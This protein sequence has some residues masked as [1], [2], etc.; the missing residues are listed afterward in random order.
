LSSVSTS[1]DFVAVTG[2]LPLGGSSTFLLNLTLARGAAGRGTDIIVLSADPPFAAD[3]RAAGATVTPLPDPGAIY[4]DRL[5]Q[6]YAILAARE[7]RAVLST[8]SAESFELLR[9]VPPGVARVGMIQ[10]H[11]PGPYRLAKLYAD[12]LDAVVGVSD[13]ICRSLRS[14]PVFAQTRIELI[15]YGIDFRS[16]SSRLTLPIGAPLRICYLG[17]LVEEQK[18][19]SRLA[20]LSERLEARQIHHRLTIAGEGPEE[21]RLRVALAGRRD[22][23][24]RGPIPNREVGQFF[25][26]QDVFVLLSDYEGLPLTLLEAMGAG[27]VPVVSDLVSGMREVVNESRG[28]LV[29]VDDIDAAVDAIRHLAGNREQL[30]SLSVAATAYVRDQFS[31]KKM[32]ARFQQLVSELGSERPIWPAEVRVPTPRGLRASW[33]FRGAPRVLRRLF[34]RAG[35][36]RPA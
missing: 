35:L 9:L 1:A 13:E 32:S 17:R 34:R 10:S 14:E 28:F 24:L 30:N 5:A 27:T 4:E 33:A 2:S 26:E 12:C 31:A 6:A 22:V 7:P 11:D 25:A 8:L 23:L 21:A 19:V 29:P 36:K 15:H 20:R 3:L 18:R 16:V